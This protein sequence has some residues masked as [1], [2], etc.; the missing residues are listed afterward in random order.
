MEDNALTTQSRSLSYGEIERIGKAFVASAMFGKDVNRVSIAITKIMAGQ[1]LGIAPFAAMRAIH[2]IEGTATLSANTM[3]GMVK[4]SGR[5]DYTVVDKSTDRCV[6]DFFEIRGGKRIKLG[7]E[8]FDVS[9]A[10]SADLLDPEC[11][12]APD[13]HAVRQV[14]RYNKW[15]RQNETVEGCLCKDNWKKYPKAMMFA[16]CMSNGVRTYCPDVF[17]GLAVYT[18]DELEPIADKPPRDTVEAELVDAP[19]ITKTQLTKL[20]ALFTEGGVTKRED[21]LRMVSD[22]IGR[23]VGSA[24]DLTKEEASK[25]IDKMSKDL[26]VAKAEPVDT[27][28]FSDDEI[29]SDDQPTEEDTVIATGEI[30]SEILAKLDSI[31]L[32]PAGRKKFLEA[33]VETTTLEDLSDAQWMKLSQR[34]DLVLSTEEVIPDDWTKPEQSAVPA[35]EED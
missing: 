29:Q 6:I 16:R 10:R 21:R 13:K 14:S 19:G 35:K 7:T 12:E 20:Q 25:L 22:T 15:R 27:S 23:E 11:T 2:I 33:A 9:E 18:P 31:G 1:E 17:N 34:I 8:T 30:K 3:A 28:D 26:E 4:S 32:N 24:N 5:Y